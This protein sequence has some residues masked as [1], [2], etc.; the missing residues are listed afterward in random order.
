M[1]ADQLKAVRRAARRRVAANEAFRE[2]V[3]DAHRSKESLRAIAAEA[4]LSHVAVL[5]IVQRAEGA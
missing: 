1:G 5:K 2:A 3:L 4:G